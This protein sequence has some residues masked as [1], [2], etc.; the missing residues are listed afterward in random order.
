MGAIGIILFLFSLTHAVM[1]IAHH[2]GLG[3]SGSFIETYSTWVA[4]PMIL[5]L[6]VSGA[7][8][9]KMA[10]WSA[11]IMNKLAQTKIVS[12]S[13]RAEVLMEQNRLLDAYEL[14]DLK[15]RLFDL[16][17]ELKAEL[18]PVVQRRIR[19]SEQLE[20]MIDDVDDPELRREVRHDIA[21][22]N[23][24]SSPT[25]SNTVVTPSVYPV[26]AQNGRP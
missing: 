16:Q 12:L 19:A 23:S 20:Q 1:A 17:T 13:N 6:C 18:I 21:E 22:L 25:Q 14:S 24:Q 10:H 8:T 11:K 15:A 26:R 4:F 5:I 2:K 3:I 7:I 9:L